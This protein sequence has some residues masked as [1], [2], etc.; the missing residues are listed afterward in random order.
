[1]DHEAGFVEKLRHHLQRTWA[2]VGSKAPYFHGYLQTALRFP[3]FYNSHAEVDATYALL[4]QQ[5]NMLVG[6][7]FSAQT[8]NLN[9]LAHSYAEMRSFLQGSRQPEPT[10]AVSTFAALVDSVSP[11]SVDK[12]VYVSE[13]KAKAGNSL[14]PKLRVGFVGSHEKGGS[15]HHQLLA[16]VVMGICALKAF[17]TVV[18]IHENAEQAQALQHAGSNSVQALQHE[19]SQ[20][21]LP[22]DVSRARRKILEEEL[23]VL[24]F[25]DLQ[26]FR[27]YQLAFN[28]L[29]PIQISAGATVGLPSIDY[30][31]SSELFGSSHHHC[32]SEQAVQFETLS[33]LPLYPQS[34]DLPN[35]LQASENRVP[36]RKMF[37]F[38]EA[39]HIYLF[40][41]NLKTLT[42]LS[43]DESLLVLLCKDSSARIV[44]VAS[45]TRLFAKLKARWQL[46]P[47][48]QCAGQRE[49]DFSS[50][51][52]II[53]QQLTP[54]QHF[55]LVAISDCLLD[56]SL[57]EPTSVLDAF[58]VG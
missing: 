30:Q 44:F 15:P 46:S 48:A 27:G 36:Y 24:I 9:F 35:V 57:G 28:R 10:A 18:F 31:V 53:H 11:L 13:A 20:V 32:Y 40:A 43:F 39:E 45:D 41:K 42:T 51:T 34:A 22:A 14:P 19:D 17:T 58:A 1:V 50:Q 8:D 33:I 37:G 23:D 55:M 49:I 26:S 2:L 21:V 56:Q 25:T 16:S 54:E 4:L 3:L 7:D 6:V 12:L 52:S 47:A 38:G 5:L 29:A